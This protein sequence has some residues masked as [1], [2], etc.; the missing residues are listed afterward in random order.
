[1][2]HLHSSSIPVRIGDCNYF[3]LIIFFIF[4]FLFF[5]LFYYYSKQNTTYKQS[6][7]LLTLVTNHLHYNTL[8]LSLFLTDVREKRKR[9]ESFIKAKQST[10]YYWSLKK[11]Y[12][13]LENEHEI[14]HK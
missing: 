12:K 13:K 10:M 14:R 2:Q 1:M 4:L 11:V 5:F 8:L 7:L 9:G 6:T 3:N